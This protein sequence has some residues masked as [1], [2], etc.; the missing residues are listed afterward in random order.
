MHTSSHNLCFY[1]FPQITEAGILKIAKCMT[2]LAALHVI[3]SG[4]CD[5]VKIRGRAMMPGRIFFRESSGERFFFNTAAFSRIWNYLVPEWDWMGYGAPGLTHLEEEEVVQVQEQQLNLP[6]EIQIQ[7]HQ[8]PLRGRGDLNNRGRGDYHNRGRGDFHYRG[9]GGRGDFHYRGGGRGDFHY[10]G[11]GRGDGHFRGGGGGVRGRGGL[12]FQVVPRGRG[13]QANGH[14]GMMG[15]VQPLHP[16]QE[17]LNQFDFE[18]PPLPAPGGGGDGPDIIHL[19]NIAQG[20][21]F[22]HEHQQQQ[23]V[24]SPPP[25]PR[26]MSLSQLRFL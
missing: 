17:G 24:Y 13:G 1:L 11:G 21:L 26:G 9:G 2:N 8:Q 25:P 16:P 6:P 10:R 3:C 19:M 14:G 7:Y 12:Q 23:P 22:L 20:A 4:L 15:H 5:S 18:L